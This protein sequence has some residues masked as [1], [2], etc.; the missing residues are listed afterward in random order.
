MKVTLLL[1]I[2][3]VVIIFSAPVLVFSISSIGSHNISGELLELQRDVKQ[4]DQ[5][6]QTVDKNVNET[7]FFITKT[8]EEYAE[9]AG[10]DIEIIQKMHRLSL[11]HDIP[12]EL[13]FEVVRHESNFD[14]NAVNYNEWN[15]T[16]DRGLFQLNDN[17]SPWLAENIG[18]NNFNRD[19]T[20]DPELNMKMGMWY[21]D[22]LHGRY[23]DWQRT[24]TA[25]NKGIGGLQ[26]FERRHGTSRSLYSRS[27]LRSVDE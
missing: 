7:H 23:N 10:T 26:S 12:F 19:I 18:I 2:L 4:L 6:L 15:N 3:L 17:T 1:I 24:L 16:Y 25:Y 11:Q 20:Y 13:A 21:L 14:P 22:Y 8:H 5:K 9:K 27:I